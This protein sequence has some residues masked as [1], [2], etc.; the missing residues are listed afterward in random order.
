[1]STYI[2]QLR[3]TRLSDVSEVGGKN[4]SSGE[5]LSRLSA[6][7][8]RVPDGFAATAAAYR[9][10][11]DC[12]GLAPRLA[13][14]M[15]QLERPSYANLPDIG[16][17]ARKLIYAALL[18]D[19]LAD[20]IADA[21]SKLEAKDGPA[22][23]AV[24]SSATAE[25]LPEASFAG[26]HES[27]LNI[28]GETA[29]LDAVQMCYASL[30]TDRAIKY[31]ED[32][33]FAHE[34]V[35]L[36][37]GVQ[38]M[39]RSDKGCSGVCFTL[40]PDSGFR[41]VIHIAGVWGL[42]ENIVQ[43]TVTPD[44][45]LV[46]KPTLETAKDP[47]LQHR[48][49]DKQLTMVYGGPSEP[50]VNTE[51]PADKRGQYVLGDAELVQLARWAL[52][53]EKHYG[54]PMDLEWAR[55]GLTGELFLI[56]A[57]PE[58]VQSRKDPY[59][60]KGYTIT[61]KGALRVSGETVGA[62]IVSGRARLLSS[63]SDAGRLEPGDIIVTEMTSPDWDPILK[64]AGAIVTDKGGRTSHAAIVAREL[65]VPAIV[66]TGNACKT[67][68]DG[69]IVTV[70]C[71]E[72]AVGFVYAGRA[73]WKE[74]STQL[75][76]IHMPETVR[77][78]LIVGDPD[79]A[80]ALSFY[81]NAGVGLMRMEFIITD[82][83]RVH[84]MAMAHFDSVKDPAVRQQIEAIAGTADKARFFIDRLAEGIAT[85]AAAFYPKEVIL[86][87]SDF[88]TN[89]YAHLLGG[90][91][92]EPREENPMLGF[93]GASRYYNPLYKDGFRL[94]CA[95][96]KKVREDMGLTNLKVMIPF[97]RTVEEGEKVLAVMAEN[98]LVRGEK[99]LQ[100]YV[101]A[102]IPSNVLLAEDF[103][104]IFDG[105]SIGSNDLTQLTLGI[106]RDS[107]LVSGLFSERNPAVRKSIHDLIHQAKASGVK[108]GLCGQAPSDYPDFAR[109][110]VAEGIDSISFNPDA[111]LNGIAQVLKAELAHENA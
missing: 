58:T 73:S 59:T 91:D 105:F 15:Q 52:L 40:D 7:G 37:V 83:I 82:Y 98:G 6:E 76:D 35:A 54:K 20:A 12:N 65:G 33:G 22:A 86:R 72:G 79:K 94:E 36:S 90:A 30:Y 34:K 5:M 31:R 47:V 18:P 84:P 100:V 96:I 106:D 17:R 1:M 11:L 63:P 14:L 70:S 68:R 104:R 51:T 25:D 55:D 57:R 80:F 53:V 64:N 19:D 89:E 93:R 62:G 78:M 99:G 88:K 56:Q 28:Q 24:R 81:P 38:R 97:C 109:F 43:G 27:Y 49:G 103:A 92:F 42:G 39:V 107:A 13:G 21:Y 60:V 26:Q 45:F 61:T 75:R 87:T 32:N 44:E 102:E 4:A 101:M 10:F 110:L 2:K 8:I 66:G 69:E 111:L 3:D 95:A 67:I 71:C 29:L 46:F 16:A 41:D 48:L 9:Y 50:T 74:T 77:P 85:V 23:V 108:V